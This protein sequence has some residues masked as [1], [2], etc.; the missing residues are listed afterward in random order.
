MRVVICCVVFAS[1]LWFFTSA[2]GQIRRADAHQHSQ[3]S[4]QLAVERSGQLSLVIRAPGANLVGFEHPPRNESQRSTLQRARLHLEKADWLRLPDSAGC[5]SSV[6]LSLPG[7]DDAENHG[8]GH[9][10]A[11]QHAEFRIEVSVSCQ[12]SEVPEW[13]ELRL[14]DDWPDNKVIVVDAISAT[15]QW[16]ERLTAEQPRLVL[17]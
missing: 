1:T 3:S 4:A 9:D 14:F 13:I 16:R 10:H 8:H 5:T 2:D 12:P 11:H 7:F 17:Q 6:N 15:G